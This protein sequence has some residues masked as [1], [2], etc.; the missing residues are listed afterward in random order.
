MLT[1]PVL[2]EPS[3]LPS[4]VS[5]FGWAARKLWETKPSTSHLDHLL[6]LITCL[7][8]PT[9]LSPEAS[10]LHE[11]VLTITACPLERAL[12]HVQKLHPRRRDIDPLLNALRP[13]LHQ[14]RSGAASHAELEAWSTAPHGGLLASLRHSFQAL[15]SWSSASVAKQEDSG[16]STRQTPSGSAP[17]YTHRLVLACVRTF[18]ACTTL[19]VLLNEAT[20]FITMGTYSAEVPLDVLTA[21]VCAPFASSARSTMSLRQALHVV[22][23]DAYGYSTGKNGQDINVI[24]AELIV[25]LSRR[26]DAQSPARQDTKQAAEDIAAQVAA[27]NT[28]G[29][30]MMEL[31]G[32]AE[33]VDGTVDGTI[34]NT[35]DTAND[36]LEG[37]LKGVRSTDLGHYMDTDNPGDLFDLT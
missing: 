18:G 35:A 4:L 5:G 7:I 25:R 37:M 21:I 17:N 22:L 24:K 36:V 2:L 3:L 23:E 32:G 29:D 34:L 27:G 11:T 9:S 15:L 16:G 6:P 33:M 31:N 28:A 20:R 1:V 19:S 30:I 12:A 13:H 14:V 10:T 8:K 26:V